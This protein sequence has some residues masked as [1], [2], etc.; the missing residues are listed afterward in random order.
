MIY[1]FLTTLLIV[2]LFLGIMDFF[3]K[4][5]KLHNE[6]SI[7]KIKN[8]EGYATILAYHMDKSYEI[9]HK[10]KILVYS[11]EAIRLSEEQFSSATKSYATLVL[12][13]LGP[14]L[15]EALVSLY[16]DEATLL[17]NIMEFFNYK[18]ERD[19]IYKT[20]SDNLMAGENDITTNLPKYNGI[21]K[22]ND[23]IQKINLTPEQSKFFGL[24]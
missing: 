3:I 22:P 23:Q 17:F 4:Y 9:I 18:Y 10:E 13:M 5:L 8:F 15:K 12:K 2:I 7:D 11:L 6:Y 14:N 21:T 24:Q 19:E 1:L 16:G 20:A